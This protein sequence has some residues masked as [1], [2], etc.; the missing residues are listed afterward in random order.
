MMINGVTPWFIMEKPKQKWMIYG[1]PHFRNHPPYGF[2]V[3]ADGSMM[4]S[5][6]ISAMMKQRLQWATH[7]DFLMRILLNRAWEAGIRSLF[8]CKHSQRRNCLA[9]GTSA[10][11]SM[12]Y[13]VSCSLK[14]VLQ[15]APVKIIYLETLKKK[16]NKN[17]PSCGNF[18]PTLES[19]YT[20]PKNARP[21]WPK[22]QTT[23]IPRTSLLQVISF[24]LHDLAG[25]P[26]SP[27]QITTAEGHH[28]RNAPFLPPLLQINAICFS[29]K[30][31]FLM[32]L[33][34]WRG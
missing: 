16:Q 8:V 21:P 23:A 2:K 24:C 34:S 4:E 29:V 10:C 32:D 5:M 12:K 14:P 28:G 30:C 13:H 27:W 18:P 19:V 11:L 26:R 7:N 3:A 17:Q 22:S 6:K 33:M 9:R 31:Q 20:M 25:F 1:Y 15:D